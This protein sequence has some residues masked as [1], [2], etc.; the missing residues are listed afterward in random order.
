MRRRG[1]HLRP[2]QVTAGQVGVVPAQQPAPGR[3]D[4]VVA[5]ATRHAEDRERILAPQLTEGR[6][7]HSVDTPLVSVPV[8]AAPADFRARSG[9]LPQGVLEDVPFVVDQT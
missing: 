2:L 4:L 7:A 5:R 1:D 3:P 9:T 8:E 6:M